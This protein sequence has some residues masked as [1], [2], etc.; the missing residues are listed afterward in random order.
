MRVTVL[1]GGA[2]AERSVAFAGAAQIVTA[3]R[4]RGHEIQ[5][6][7]TVTGLLSASE[8]QRVLSAQVGPEPPATDELDEQER[9]FLSAELAELAA[10]RQADVTGIVTRYDVLHQLA[11][12]R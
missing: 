10:V 5:V 7:D 3:L 8:E 9:H 2:T 6:V 1:T 4:G 11:G 12:I